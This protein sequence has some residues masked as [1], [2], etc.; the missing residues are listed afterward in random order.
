MRIVEVPHNWGEVNGFRD[1][2]VAE[3][4]GAGLNGDVNIESTSEGRKIQ[5]RTPD[6]DALPDGFGSTVPSDAFTIVETDD[7][8]R[9]Q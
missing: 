5:V 4:R 7:I 2:L 8:T 6:V 3:L 9:E 1:T